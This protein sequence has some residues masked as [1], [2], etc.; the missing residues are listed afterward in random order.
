VSDASEDGAGAT[1][2]PVST[3]A[4][5]DLLVDL[6]ST[7]SVSGEEDAAAERLVSFL[8]RH[9]RAVHRDAVGNVRAPGD[10]AV[11]LT[12]HLDTVPGEVPVRVEETP[13]GEVL[14]GRGSV[15]ATG[16]LA[17]MA[18]AA[19]RTG[20]S[21]AGVVREETDSAGARHLVADREAPE[22]VVNGEPSGTDG[23]T[24]GYRGFQAGT[25]TAATEST[26]S[27]RPEPNAVQAATRWWGRVEE[28]FAHDPDAPV[29]EQVT[30]KP[31][32]VDGGLAADGT[33]VEATADVQFRLPP[34]TT[35]AAVRS[36]VEG[37]LSAGRI[38]WS[39]PIPP[40]LASPR[41]P[42]A[43]ALRAAIREEGGDPRLVRKTGTSDQNLYADAWDCPTATYGPGD[44]ELDHAPD[45][46][47]SLAEFDDAVAVLTSVAANLVGTDP[48]T[49]QTDAEA[50]RTDPQTAP[51][52]EGA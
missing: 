19:V 40:V 52:G 38:D 21:F 30:A 9:G 41:T 1:T 39:D 7:P 16:P 2:A 45:E 24:L 15:D 3:A 18:A 25:Y 49:G 50:G 28:A 14:W 8:E 29:F 27:S 23:V 34:G 32:A 31:V 22:A 5:R 47:L 10:D 33:S 12:S 11:L 44:S 35:A 37:L 20:A 6:V 42:V 13:A 48:A 43:R 17:A 36:T 26:H 4:A 46:R 51:G